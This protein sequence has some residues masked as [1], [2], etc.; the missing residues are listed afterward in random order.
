MLTFF[1]FEDYHVRVSL[2][3]VWCQKS[4]L[5]L[6][7]GHLC[8]CEGV[9]G[10]GNRQGAH[11]LPSGLSQAS[12]LCL[13][14]WLPWAPTGAIG[15][16]SYLCLQNKCVI[17]LHLFLT[18]MCFPSSVH[19]ECQRISTLNQKSL[20]QNW[21]IVWKKYRR[22]V[23]QRRNWRSALNAS[24]RSVTSLPLIPTQ[25][26]LLTAHHRSFLSCHESNVGD[27]ICHLRG[28]PASS[29][30]PQELHGAVCHVQGAVR[31]SL[32]SD[33]RCGT[34]V[35]TSVLLGTV[36]ALHCLWHPHCPVHHRLCKPCL[37]CEDDS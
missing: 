22:N 18:P 23:K 11:E 15:I 35:P 10:A 32:L 26:H 25:G 36:G 6:A 13:P 12:P 37:S 27:H 24:E 8:L 7:L 9:Y 20:L 4:L 33:T 34:A 16:P 30:S 2:N 21:S 29:L 28:A 5:L 14:A 1:N 19:I 3:G 17:F 31:S